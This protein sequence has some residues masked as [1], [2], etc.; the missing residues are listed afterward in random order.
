MAVEIEVIVQRGVD[1]G[2]L[3]KVAHP[4][5][6]A[7]RAL[8]SSE[9]KMA[10]FGPVV[11]V[12]TDLLAVDIPDGFHRCAIGSE[13]VCYDGFRRAVALHRFLQ[14]PQRS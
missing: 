8:S 14:K 5:E 12:T 13:P 10:V 1:R 4:S 6:P 7:H 3:L 2:E 9:G 11:E